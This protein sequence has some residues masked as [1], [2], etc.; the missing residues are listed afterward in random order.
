MNRRIAEAFFYGLEPPTCSKCQITS[1]TRRAT[2]VGCRQQVGANLASQRKRGGVPGG[3]LLTDA[4][5]GFL[6]I[7]EPGA[8]SW[9]AGCKLGA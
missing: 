9:G 3:L 8:D 6:K 7:L 1:L 5:T 2:K 4:S